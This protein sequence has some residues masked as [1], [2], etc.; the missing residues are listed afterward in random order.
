MT[1]FPPWQR[2]PWRNLTDRLHRD[3]V[4]HAILLTG[5]AGLGKREFARRFAY[6]LLCETRGNTPCGQCRACRLTQ[7]G[8]H[9]DCTTVTLECRDDGKLRSE[10]TIDQIRALSERLALTSQFGGYQIALI[11]PADCLNASAA[12]GLL[13][14]LEEP[15]VG[16]IILLV[17]DQPARLP[18]T[19]RSRC[20]RINFHLP[21]ERD[22]TEWLSNQGI[23]NPA[24]ALAASG[25]NPGLALTWAQ[26]GTLA[27]REEIA[28]DLHELSTGNGAPLDLANRWSRDNMDLRLWFA[29][30]LVYEEIRAQATKRKGPLGLADAGNFS[31]LSVQLSQ[32]FEQVNRARQQ[33]TG[34]L[35]LELIAFE[36]LTA[37][38]H[39]AACLRRK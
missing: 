23:A 14:T 22:G 36:L 1:T 25:G 20:Q 6:F 38:C 18:A 9:P 29:A 24:A 39:S 13:K 33:L 28:K 21:N 2:E 12:N 26:A 19:I 32:W 10:L 30:T 17:S 27:L 11:Y 31:K 3:A 35:R 4:P 16:T 7:A 37:W 8:S 34:P 5:A 15:P